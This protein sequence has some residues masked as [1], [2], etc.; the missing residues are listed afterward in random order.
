[1]TD[2]DEDAMEPAEA[3]TNETWDD[4]GVD[5]S[6]GV[7]VVVPTH[8][9]PK[10]LMGCLKALAS[11]RMDHRRF[12]VVVVDHASNGELYPVVERFAA[13]SE[14][15]VRYLTIAGARGMAAARNV[16]WRAASGEIVAFTDEGCVPDPGWLAAGL[17]AFDPGVQGVQG[18]VV[19]P[20]PAS[21]TEHERNVSRL[22]LGEFVT[23]NCFYRRDALE[24]VGGFD[25]RFR[26]A[27]SVDRD[28]FFSLLERGGAFQHAEG[29]VVVQPVRPARWGISLA[30]PGM[31]ASSALLYKKH[32]ALYRARIQARPPW[33]TYATTLALVMAVT[34]AAR[35]RPRPAAVAAA[36]WLALTARHCARRLAGTARTPSHV[37]EMLVTSA[38]IP[39]LSAYWRL[40]GALRHRVRFL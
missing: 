20:L 21:P 39:P 5:R 18:R 10:A 8:R 13:S 2:A 14:L 12:E 11:Q 31:G 7:T 22:A 30:E 32:P 29:A 34:S 38:L 17:A 26:A 37:A 24:A 36:T 25:E 33:T 35:R 1:M 4:D 6:I 40:R 27:W 28:L 15:R 23:T 19:V 9:R 16:G 3:G